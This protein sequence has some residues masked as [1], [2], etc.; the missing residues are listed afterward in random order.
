MARSRRMGIGV[1]A[2]LVALLV[3]T[4]LPAAAVPRG[5]RLGRSN[6]FGAEGAAFAP[7]ELSQDVTISNPLLGER[8]FSIRSKARFAGFAFVLEREGSAAV[9]VGGRVEAAG[10]KGY[11]FL[12]AEPLDGIQAEYSLPKGKYELFV[13]SSDPD[14]T[15]KVSL[16]LADLSGSTT[17]ALRSKASFEIQFPQVRQDAGG[18]IHSFDATGNFVTDAGVLFGGSWFATPAQGPTRAEACFYKGETPPELNGRATGCTSLSLVTQVAGYDVFD[19][20]TGGQT[21]TNPQ[22]TTSPYVNFVPAGR[23]FSE[24]DN[25]LPG[26]FSEILTAET[27]S[28]P[29]D[30]QA[31][32]FWL[33]F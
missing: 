27:A 8:T 32:A 14:A 31:V 21:Q 22:P 20:V 9:W 17:L 13:F 26:R 15:T 25:W 29:E 28:L 4:G 1:A 2:A 6:T 18:Q 24:A 12:S 11:F 7:V 10:R 5:S 30:L 19:G 16:R 23:V 3:A 33:G